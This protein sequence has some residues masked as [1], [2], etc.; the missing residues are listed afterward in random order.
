MIFGSV[1][2]LAVL[3]LLYFMAQKKVGFGS[4]VM[5]AML[6]GLVVGM[7]FKEKIEFIGTLGQ[8]YIN[9][10]KMIVMPLVAVSIISS[11]NTLSDP[12]QL[13]NIGVKTI[14]LFLLTTAIAATIGVVVGIV[15][16]PGAGVS[17]IADAS[18][19]TREIPAFTKVLLDLVPANP[20]SEM[21]NGK[22]IPVIIFSLFIGV[23]ISIE[24][25][26]N[27]ERIQPVKDF[28]NA[29]TRV[30]HRVTKM[31]ILFTPYGV[32]GLMAAMAGK[33]GFAALLPLGKVIIAVYIACLIHLLLTYGSLV[34]FVVKINPIK[35]LQKVYP[36]IVVAFTTRSSYATLPINLEV[37]TKRLKVSEKIA[38]FVTPLGAT[39]NMNGCGGLWPAIVAIFV[40]AIYNIDLTLTDYF[41]IVGSATMAS[42]GTAGIPG[43]ASISTTV[44]LASLGLPLEG[45]A[46]VLGIDPIVDMARTAINALGT[47]VSALVIANSEQAVDLTAFENTSK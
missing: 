36:V 5:L 29:F 20:V 8:I 42:I 26:R 43:P 24:S 44:V 3:A 6:L 22:V 4:R 7:V 46:I 37:I 45:M 2:T 9:L 27:E 16:N 21:A 34:A 33:Y 41:L 12:K 10:I 23:A 30:M 15:V 13:K 25:A 32:F 35:F 38:S 28:I 39:M 47:T 17:L 14:G 11:I 19:K 18:F 40:A 31:V 1:V